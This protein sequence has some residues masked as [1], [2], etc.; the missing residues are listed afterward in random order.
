MASVLSTVVSLIHATKR[1]S[2]ACALDDLD[3]AE[4]RDDL[5]L[6]TGIRSAPSPAIVRFWF[7]SHKGDA[8]RVLDALL[9][10]H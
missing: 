4:A 2:N 7:Y 3:E 8:N 1:T 10:G 6:N 9:D 5:V